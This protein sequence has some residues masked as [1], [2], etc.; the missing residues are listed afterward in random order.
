MGMRCR[1]RCGMWTRGESSFLRLLLVWSTHGAEQRQAQQRDFSSGTCSMTIIATRCLKGL[2]MLQ[3]V[4][5]RRGQRV[6]QQRRSSVLPGRFGL[7]LGGILGQTLDWV[8]E[9]RP[10]TIQFSVLLVEVQRQVITGI[11]ISTFLDRASE[12]SPCKQAIP[13]LRRLSA[14]SRLNCWL[15]WPSSSEGR[16][17]ASPFTPSTKYLRWMVQ[18]ILRLGLLRL[19]CHSNSLLQ[20]KPI[21]FGS[22]YIRTV[23][24]LTSPRTGRMTLKN[25]RCAMRL[26]HFQASLLLPRVF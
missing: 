4:R 17:R 24:M 6:E 14:V 26:Q 16:V 8:G 21:P 15:L 12:A 9:K 22:T 10:A 25:G 5:S 1:T 3:R 20:F 23:P 18:L 19:E 11:T 2:K 7:A 13:R